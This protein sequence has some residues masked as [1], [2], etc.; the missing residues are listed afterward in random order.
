MNS[1]SRK[2]PWGRSAFTTSNILQILS[3]VSG[4]KKN[5]FEKINLRDLADQILSIEN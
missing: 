4:L 2:L 5:E 3:D 1:S